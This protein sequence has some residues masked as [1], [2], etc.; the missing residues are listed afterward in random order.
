MN[1]KS[2]IE[3]GP[4][5]VIRRTDAQKGGG[6]IATVAFQ[7][8]HSL[9]WIVLATLLFADSIY[10]L[11]TSPAPLQ[12]DR[13]SFVDQSWL[14]DTAYKFHQGLWLGRDSVF[15]YGPLF[16]WMLGVSSSIHGLSLGS[17][18]RTGQ[19]L[20]SVYAIIA[21]FTFARLLLSGHTPWK[22]AFYLMCL[23]VFWGYL[24]LR[25]PTV[26]LLFA[27]SLNE[28]SRAA[29]DGFSGLRLTG[30]ALALSITFLI[31]ADTGAYSC[32]SFLAA[33]FALALCSADRSV[34]LR[35]GRVVAVVLAFL[36]IS[37]LLVGF[38]V[39][40]WS[41]EF[42][43]D[44]EATLASYRWSLAAG[45]TRVIALRMVAIFT[46]A[47]GIL[48]I[49]WWRRN[50]HAQSLA[51]TPAFFLSSAALAFACLQSGVVR[52]DWGHVA[53]ALYPSILLA[54]LVLMGS[55]ASE[56]RGRGVLPLF[57]ALGLTAVASGTGSMYVP[58]VLASKIRTVLERPRLD[59]EN[60]CSAGTV[61]YQGVCLFETD[62]QRLSGVAGYLQTHTAPSQFIAIFPY[63]NLY[64]DMAGRRVA[65]GV[66]QAYAAAAPLLV[67]RHIRVLEMQDPSVGVFSADDVATYGIDGV[68]NFTRSPEPWLY[69]QARYST[70]TEAQPGIYIL[71]R[72]RDRQERW[73][74][75]FTNLPLASNPQPVQWI[76]GEEWTVSDH[77]NWPPAADFLKV[78]LRVRYPVSW[79]FLKPRPVLV[80]LR[81]SDGYEKTVLAVIPPDREASLWICPWQ[82][83][84]LAQY[85]SPDPG[86]WHKGRWAR[87]PVSVRIGFK[88]LDRASVR[89][90]RAELLS[91]QAAT[92]ALR[93]S[94]KATAYIP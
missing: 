61:A 49:G 50:P 80:K 90:K 20:T 86:S 1:P 19:F 59:S 4:A 60:A 21:T 51:R 26:L 68:P 62:F 73:H 37:M 5:G 71:R 91:V 6:R 15:T 34:W 84:Q 52:S 66:L 23:V 45:I 77:L 72:D 13:I 87:T 24:D 14:V 32:L 2:S 46:C 78:R 3:G 85:F 8:W 82:E 42:W 27:A 36:L 22:R 12:V 64:A 55:E 70:E 54:G 89:P 48:A 41:L 9:D 28:L 58:G 81:Y 93:E 83:R 17:Y 7:L 92:I 16:E 31:S 65:G 88:R 44:N 56:A 39:V 18:F 10:F 40:P 35:L 53:F 25:M 33:A 79:H 67:Q 29:K 43:R 75:S 11:C 30:L 57:V 69:L 63:E 38:V 76:Q 74:M 94:S 47:A